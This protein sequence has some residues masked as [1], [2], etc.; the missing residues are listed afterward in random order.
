M[1]ITIDLDKKVVNVDNKEYKII[2]N[3]ELQLGDYCCTDYG[4]EMFILFDV[5]KLQHYKLHSE[6]NVYKDDETMSFK[7]HHTEW[8]IEEL[9]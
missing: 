6:Y 5:E 1:N 7:K 8:N 4:Q 9:N 2:Y 3:C